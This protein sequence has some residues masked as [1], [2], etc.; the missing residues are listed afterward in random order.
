MPAIGDAHVLAAGIINDQHVNKLPSTVK[1][2]QPV[3]KALE[4]IPTWPKNCGSNFC[5]QE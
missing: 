5:P 3:R 1:D 4:T 2:A